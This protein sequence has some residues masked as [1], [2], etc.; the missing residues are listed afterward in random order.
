MNDRITAFVLSQSDYRENDVLMQASCKEY[1]ILT[2]VGKA[3]KKL[4]SRNHFLPMCLYEFIIDYKDDKSIYSVHGYKL[5][6]DYFEDKDIEMMSFKN[7]ICEL[8]LKNR[9]IDTFDQLCFVFRNMDKDNRYLLGSM[10]LSHIIKHFGIT[11]IVDHCALCDSTKVVAFSNTHGGFLCE[12]HLGGDQIL[13]VETLRKFRLII[14]GDF[15]NYDVLKQFDYEYRDFSLLMDFY[16]AH[17]D[18]SLKS[19]RFY[20]SV[21]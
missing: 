11:P 3:A 12:K 10:F 4:S 16:L 8:V 15:V 13:P 20:Q 21:C 9:D 19:Y 14:K 5:L 1:G 18:V 7:M 2:L 17:S 6:E